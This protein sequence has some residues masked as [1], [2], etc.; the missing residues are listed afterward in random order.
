MA[1]KPCTVV[2]LV[3]FFAVMGKKYA[4]QSDLELFVNPLGESTIV[5]TMLDTAFTY[6]QGNG[7]E[8]S[9]Y[10]GVKELNTTG[11]DIWDSD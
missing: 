1:R 10:W 7:T 11:V 5:D 4:P 8:V 9:L 3:W 2:Y 6:G